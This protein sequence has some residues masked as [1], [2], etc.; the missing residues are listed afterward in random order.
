MISSKRALAG[1]DHQMRNIGPEPDVVQRDQIVGI[2]HRHP[3]AAHFA[4]QGND[5]VLAYQV[6]GQ[7]TEQLRVGSDVVEI[8]HLD[9]EL[10]AHG[11]A[12]I[13]FLAQF[14]LDENGP[15]PPPG[16]PLNLQSSLDVLGFDHSCPDQELSQAKPSAHPDPSH[17]CSSR[18]AVG[19][20]KLDII[21]VHAAP[22]P[23]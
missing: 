3:Q 12:D 9:P 6:E 13:F 15:Q 18:F 16:C 10:I 14:E 8:H 2:D 19:P 21:L 4:F 11:L 23:C 17:P 20:A 7:D 22:F 1:G 5:L